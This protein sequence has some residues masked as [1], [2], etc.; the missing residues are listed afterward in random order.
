MAMVSCPAPGFLPS[1]ICSSMS[2]WD[3]RSL[4]ETDKNGLDYMLT[5]SPST[6]PGGPGSGRVQL[7]GH[8]YVFKQTSS[9]CQGFVHRP[10]CPQPQ[11]SAGCSCPVSRS[12]EDQP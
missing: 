12:W 6:E 9:G 2:A 5:S 11:E 3:R 8:L 10:C 7:E 1:Q 4:L